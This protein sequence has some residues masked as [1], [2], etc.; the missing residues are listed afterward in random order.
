MRKG[1][2]ADRAN[3]RWRVTAEPLREQRGAGYRGGATAAQKARFDDAAVF[4]SNGK[5]KNVA[6]NGIADFNGCIGVRE[7]T[8]VARVAEVIEDGVAEHLEKY[9]ND[10]DY[11]FLDGKYFLSMEAMTT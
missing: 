11:L 2:G 3:F 6:A 4:D 7:F 9:S 1:C 10:R 8:G 5:L